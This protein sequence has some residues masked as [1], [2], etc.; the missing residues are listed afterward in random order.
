MLSQEQIKLFGYTQAGGINPVGVYT[1]NTVS[2]AWEKQA[3]ISSGGSSAV[4][5]ADG[6]NVTQGAIADAAVTTNAPGTLSAKLRG[7]VTILASVWDSV[8]NRLKVDGSGVTQPVSGTFFQ[9][10]QPVSGTFFQATQPVSGPLTDAQLRATPVPVTG[11]ITA[12]TTL[13]SITGPITPGTAAANLGKAEDAAHTSGDT[14]VF[15]FGVVND[16]D[17]DLVNANLKYSALATDRAGRQKVR[18]APQQIATTLSA[19]NAT[20]TL[21]IAAAGAGLF[22]YITSVEIVNVNPTAT[23]IAGSAV[24]LAYTT[25]NIPG[26]PAWTAGNALAAGAEKVVERVSYPGGIKTTTAATATTFVAPAIG[27]GGLCRIMV[28]YYIAP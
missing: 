24:T 20:V 8:N 11:T 15:V 19:A 5:M 3:P 14:G 1:W 16:L 7:I 26:A 17:V 6:A 23:A 22:H 2:L 4:T 28:T 27:A 18:E 9:A 21:T 13:G 10:T 25:T 12:V